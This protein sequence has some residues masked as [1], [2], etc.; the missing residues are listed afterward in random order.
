MM[1]W[2]RFFGSS[3]GRF[4][5]YLYWERAVVEGRTR[6]V[7][8]GRSFVASVGVST[9]VGGF[10]IGDRIRLTD[11]ASGES[12]RHCEVWYGSLFDLIHS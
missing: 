8:D 1:V 7:R 11:G 9:F 2:A 5:S 12:G 6:G 3:V 10:D 4:D